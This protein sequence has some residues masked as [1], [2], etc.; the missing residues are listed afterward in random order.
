MRDA[1]RG[2]ARPVAKSL[3]R[4]PEERLAGGSPARDPP[5]GAS[6]EEFAGSCPPPVHAVA[7]RAAVRARRCDHVITDPRLSSLPRN[8]LVCDSLDGFRAARFAQTQIMSIN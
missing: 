4:S 7:C 2:S 5:A 8:L 3:C 6:G 1:A